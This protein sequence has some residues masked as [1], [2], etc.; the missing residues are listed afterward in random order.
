VIR[1]ADPRSAFGAFLDQFAAEMT[2]LQT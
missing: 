1:P 2:P